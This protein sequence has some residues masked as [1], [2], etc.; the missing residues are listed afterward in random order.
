MLVVYRLEHQFLATALWKFQSKL[1]DVKKD[2]QN[3]LFECL[4]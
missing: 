1:I 4:F 3:Y 2:T